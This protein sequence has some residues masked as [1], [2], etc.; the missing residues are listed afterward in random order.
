M[1]KRTIGG[2]PQAQKILLSF[3]E[4]FIRQ[5]LRNKVFPPSVFTEA[6]ATAQTGPIGE[7]EM[8]QPP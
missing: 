7:G 1:N 4:W 3:W 5:K 8:N 2:G 6:V